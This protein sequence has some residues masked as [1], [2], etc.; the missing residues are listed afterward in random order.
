MAEVLPCQ[1]REL[2][3][4]RWAHGS[5]RAHRANDFRH[6]RCKGLH[7][8]GPL[9]N[10]PSVQRDPPYCIAVVKTADEQFRPSCCLLGTTR[11]D[12]CGGTIQAPCKV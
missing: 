11:Y 6:R 9:C 12:Y 7:H 10:G 3:L 5:G 2:V 4:L 8:G 1:D